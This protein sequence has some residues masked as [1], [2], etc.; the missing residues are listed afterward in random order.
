MLSKDKKLKLDG[1]ASW[2]D[3]LYFYKSGNWTCLTTTPQGKM[4]VERGYFMRRAGRKLYKQTKLIKQL[5]VSSLLEEPFFSNTAG[6]K[7]S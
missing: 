2:Q 5:H 7:W 3:E 6:E 4:H 1:Q